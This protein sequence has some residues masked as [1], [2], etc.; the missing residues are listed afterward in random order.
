[1][2]HSLIPSLCFMKRT[3]GDWTPERWKKTIARPAVLVLLVRKHPYNVRKEIRYVLCADTLTPTHAAIRPKPYLAYRYFKNLQTKV[4]KKNLQ[5]VYEEKIQTR[6]KASYTVVK[7]NIRVSI[8]ETSLPSTLFLSG[9]T[10][11][12]NIFWKDWLLPGLYPG[13]FVIA[14]IKAK[15]SPG[16]RTRTA[17]EVA[18][19]LHS[20]Y[21]K[22][23]VLSY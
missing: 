12:V 21:Y 13:V 9:V 11:S 1:M 5:A 6:W 14:L 18:A 22:F 19:H 15:E 16:I 17:K 4:Q 20:R 3:S 23:S 10:R 7:R 8:P 2:V